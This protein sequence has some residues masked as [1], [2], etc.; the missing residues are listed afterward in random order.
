MKIESL[1]EYIVLTHYLNFT[2][3]AANLHTSQPNLSKHILELEQELGVDLLKRGKRL[4]LTPAGTAFLEDAIQVHHAYKDALRRAREIA[5]HDI[6]EL[7]V[8][9]PYVMDAMSEI[10]FKS[11]MRF[12]RENPYVLTKYY[13]EKGKKSVELLEQGK[14]DIALTVDCNSIEWIEQVSEKKD[15]IFFP[16]IQERLHVW[17]GDHHPLTRK[18]SIMLDD[19]LH[20]PINM[21]ATRSFDPMRYAVLDLFLKTLGT[22]PTLQTYSSDSLNE[23]FMNTQDRNAVFLVSEAVANSQL[24]QMHRDMT[25]RPVDDERACIT[26]YLLFRS[27]YE[28]LAI[29]RFLETVE[30]VVAGSVERSATARYLSDIAVGL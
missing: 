25:S 29:D 13:Q 9:E 21:T 27:D 6:V 16:V 12:K 1:Y 4:E 15:L 8:Q 30:K 23:F 22:K 26:S 20:V 11:V 24:L 3:A 5:S 28:K 17:M 14:I 7:V 10:L 2:T 19:L 18:E